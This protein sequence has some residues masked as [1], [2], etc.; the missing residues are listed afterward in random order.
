VIATTTVSILGGVTADDG[1]GDSADNATVS[2][3]GVPA[4]ILE[5]ERRTTGYRD[6]MPRVVRYVTGRLPAGT[7]VTEDNRILD[8]NTGQIYIIDSIAKPAFFV[9]VGGLKLALTRT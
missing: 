5:Q 3:S 8:E 4:S 7:A 6:G 1:F 2:A 9:G